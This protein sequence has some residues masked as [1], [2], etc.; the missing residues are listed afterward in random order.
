M[1]LCFR[2]SRCLM[3]SCVIV[4]W[5]IVSGVFLL[6]EVCLFWVVGVCLVWVFI[7]GFFSLIGILRMMFFVFWC[8]R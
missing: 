8:F 4:F 6:S 2:L 5:L 1:V 7:V 3:V